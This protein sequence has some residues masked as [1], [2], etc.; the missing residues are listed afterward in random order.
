MKTFYV[1]ILVEHTGS[2]SSGIPG[3]LQPDFLALLNRGNATPSRIDWSD[4]RRSGVTVVTYEVPAENQFDAMLKA[5]NL[6]TELLQ[7][8]LHD[9]SAALSGLEAEEVEGVH[10]NAEPPVFSG[11]NV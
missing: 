5:N 1:R 3:R 6:F 10:R 7:P 9:F 11:G 2:G 4:I 8:H